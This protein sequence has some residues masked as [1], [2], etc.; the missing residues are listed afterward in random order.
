MKRIALACRLIALTL[1]VSMSASFPARPA[2]KCASPESPEDLA[3][4]RHELDSLK[5]RYRVDESRVCVDE[6]DGGRFSTIV[7]RL[8]GLSKEDRRLALYLRLI[9]D[10]Q[11]EQGFAFL[12]SQKEAGDR[13]TLREFEDWFRPDAPPQMQALGADW[14]NKAAKTGNADAQVQLALQYLKSDKNGERL[15]E[16]IRLLDSA[17]DQGHQYALFVLSQMDGNALQSRG[18]TSKYVRK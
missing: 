16:A 6:A 18:I 4:L 13:W 3:L 11:Y 15:A 14:L 1:L 5:M 10:R 2:D 17:A 8:F 7:G 9:R 12:L